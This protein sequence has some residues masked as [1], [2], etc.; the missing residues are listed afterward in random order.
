MQEDLGRPGGLS[1]DGSSQQVVSPVPAS[2]PDAKC[3]N[4]GV[5]CECNHDEYPLCWP[6][7]DQM[8]CEWAMRDGDAIAKRIAAQAMEARRAETEPGS[9]HDSA[10]TK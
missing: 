5:S 4:C 3:G 10:V 6:C 7:L 2:I 8:W 1:S 9:V